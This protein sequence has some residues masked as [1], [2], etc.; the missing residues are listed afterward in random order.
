MNE[1]LKRMWDENRKKDISSQKEFRPLWDNQRQVNQL[2][3]RTPP[4]F[5]SKER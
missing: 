1:N 5:Q 3:L 2:K 4:N